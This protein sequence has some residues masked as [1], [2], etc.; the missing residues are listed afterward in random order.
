ML[1]FFEW[2]NDLDT[3]LQA[4]IILGAC[5]VLAAIV[6]AVATLLIHILRRKQSKTEQLV[7]VE[8]VYPP[9]PASD[10]P[11]LSL[12]TSTTL[13][14]YFAHPYPLQENFTGRK[15][16]REK[17]TEWFTKSRQPMLVYIAMGVMQVW[18]LL[19]R[20]MR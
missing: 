10:K 11:I 14:P 12:E 19:I 1:S 7:R 9:P 15:V 18:V 2:F 3:G 4:A 20:V 5:T 17:L 16:E 6:A 13:A 8:L